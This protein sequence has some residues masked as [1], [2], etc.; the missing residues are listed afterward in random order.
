MNKS[1]KRYQK[2]TCTKPLL[3]PATAAA[4][5]LVLIFAPMAYPDTSSAKY[6]EY[7]VKAAFIY[8]FLKFVDWPEEKMSG[9]SNE[10]IIGIIGEDPFGSAADI[11]KGKTVED[12]K[13]V[14]KRFET[15]EHIKKMAEQDRNEQLGLIRKCHLLFVCPSEQKLASEITKL[16][17]KDAVLTV[18]DNDRFIESGGM[19]NLFIEDNRI[20]FDINLLASKKA[21][22]EMRSQ[23]VRLARKVI[24]NEQDAT[25]PRTGTDKKDGG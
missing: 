16:V 14:V 18:G 11:F 19:I 8:N 7:E 5:C 25:P 22:L 6:K 23:L 2:L 24:K 20:R 12:R 13:V 10:I 4:I 9:D 15:L 3:A 1:K 21:G 17:E